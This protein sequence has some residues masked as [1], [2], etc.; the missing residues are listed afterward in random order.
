MVHGKNNAGSV[1]RNTKQ[2]SGW[3]PLLVSLSVGMGAVLL[4]SA[5]VIWPV[6]YFEKW[7]GDPLDSIMLIAGFSLLLAG[8]HW[9]DREDTLIR[10]AHRKS[11]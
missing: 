8:V 6:C 4:I 3:I 11:L 7:P 2:L 9:L 1:G 5:L 10:T